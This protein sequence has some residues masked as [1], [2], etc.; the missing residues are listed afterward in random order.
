MA[1]FQVPQFIETEDKIIGPLT[2][3]QFGY[4]GTAGFVVFL[5]FFFLNIFLWFLVAG[6][7]IAIAVGLAFGKVNGRPVIVFVTAFMDS[8]WKPKVYVFK[9]SS[10]THAVQQKAPAIAIKEVDKAKVPKKPLFGGIKG[11]RDWIATSKTAIPRREKP[12][13]RSF[14]KPHYFVVA[15]SVTL[16]VQFAVELVLVALVRAARFVWERE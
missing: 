1:Q 13:P 10:A 7:F 9:P 6:V 2:L 15:D 16:L 12:L 3:K 11:L 5:L 14:G 4:I 8:V